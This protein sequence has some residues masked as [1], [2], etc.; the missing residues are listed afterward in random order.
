MKK[1]TYIIETKSLKANDNSTEEFCV[2]ADTEAEAWNKA[3]DYFNA[4]DFKI[5]SIWK[6]G[7]NDGYHNDD[8]IWVR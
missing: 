4:A 6:S 7:N 3:D 8:N 2:N 1:Y 5:T